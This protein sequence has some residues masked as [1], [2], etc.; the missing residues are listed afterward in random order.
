MI[1]VALSVFLAGAT[2]ADLY[3]RIQREQSVEPGV[4]EAVMR[5]YDEMLA[6]YLKGDQ[7]AL[8]GAALFNDREIAHM[9]DVYD[10]FS[11]ARVVRNATIAVG[12]LLMFT[13]FYRNGRWRPTFERGCAVG[14]ALFFAPLIAVGIWAAIDFTAAFN[15][16]H[17]LLFRND[18]WLLNPGTDLMIRMLPEAFFV[19]VAK[20]LAPLSLIAAL[21]VPVAALVLT[22]R[23][24]VGRVQV[25]GI[26]DDTR[27][28]EHDL[29]R[30][31][32]SRKDG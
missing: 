12:L 32:C 13:A 21:A 23:L 5:E 3:F 6:D 18:L 1:A 27:G 15:G 28:D 17:T 2:D 11:L 7:S 16:M 14:S 31:A 10:L 26:T 29:I 19:S 22:G 4:S 8:D 20:E 9:R 25:H 30:R 24:Q